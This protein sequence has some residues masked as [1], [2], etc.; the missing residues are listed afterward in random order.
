MFIPEESFVDGNGNYA[1]GFEQ[2]GLTG[3]NT[4]PNS[5]GWYKDEDWVPEI[6]QFIK[7][8]AR[9]GEYS[10]VVDLK[11]GIGTLQNI[12]AA[13]INY[14]LTLKP[15]TQ[16]RISFWAKNTN[17]M[18]GVTVYDGD[19]NQLLWTYPYSGEGDGWGEVEATFTTGED[20]KIRLRLSNLKQEDAYLKIDDFSIK[21]VR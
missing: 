18:Y 5:N 11:N 7:G 21:E 3:S 10:F 9:T 4:W 15:N 13:R 16:Y 17:I 19:G 12:Y 20:G 2:G 8:D 14:N 1:G 6:G